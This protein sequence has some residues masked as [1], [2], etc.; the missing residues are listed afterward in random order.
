MER[1][2]RSYAVLAGIAHKSNK[3]LEEVL[4]VHYECETENIPQQAEQSPTLHKNL[5]SCGGEIQKRP[6]ET[7]AVNAQKKKGK[8]SKNIFCAQVLVGEELERAMACFQSVG[9]P[10][11]VAG[12]AKCWQCEGCTGMHPPSAQRGVL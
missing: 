6:S 3:M 11:A 5:Q 2:S 1:N 7:N 9:R 8:G 12:S 4:S 10:T